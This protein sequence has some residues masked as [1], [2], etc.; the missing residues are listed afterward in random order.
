MNILEVVIGVLRGQA[1]EARRAPSLARQPAVRAAASPDRRRELAAPVKM[2]DAMERV[3][4]DGYNA[5]WM[6]RKARDEAEDLDHFG[7]DALR[8]ARVGREEAQR[9]VVD[10][11]EHLQVI[12]GRMAARRSK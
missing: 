11:D 7:E 3:A 1:R 8:Q 10:A 5:A 6:R 4:E 2:E 12:L 9:L